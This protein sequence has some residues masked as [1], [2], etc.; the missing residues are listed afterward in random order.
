MRPSYRTTS[1]APF[2]LAHPFLCHVSLSPESGARD[3]QRSQKAVQTTCR[4]VV[5][6]QTP[7]DSSS[8]HASGK[9][10]PAVP[11]GR[12]RGLQDY[13]GREQS[14]AL[15]QARSGHRHPSL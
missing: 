11:P 13:Q 10:G 2:C 14:P 15:R 8:E 6:G 12:H 9:E 3:T 7:T 4:M 5:R 1:P